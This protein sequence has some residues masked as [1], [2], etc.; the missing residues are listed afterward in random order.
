[1]GDPFKDSGVIPGDYS[2]AN[3]QRMRAFA[4]KNPKAFNERLNKLDPDEYR[5]TRKLANMLIQQYPDRFPG[6]TAD[7]VVDMMQKIAKVETGDKNI[8]Q[9][10]KG[11][12]RGFYQIETTTAP[13]ALK[14][15]QNYQQILAPL[16]AVPLPQ[17]KLRPSADVMNLSKDQQTMLA[18]SNMVAKARTGVI[19][20]NNP[21]NTW[22]DYHWSGS[23]EQRPERIQHWIDTFR[24]S[25]AKGGW[26]YPTNTGYP[27]FAD[28]GPVTWSIVEDRPMAG[29]GMFTGYTAEPST[30]RTNVPQ[31]VQAL[32]AAREFQS[33]LKN[34]RVTEEQFKSKHGISR[35]QFRNKPSNFDVAMNQVWQ[36]AKEPFKFIGADPDL[37]RE[38]PSVGIPQAL[39]GVLMSEL[40]VGEIYQAGKSAV[41]GAGKALTKE[42]KNLAIASLLSR[43]VRN[44]RPFV[45]EAPKIVRVDPINR[46]T[47]NVKN[48][49]Q[50]LLGQHQY[51]QF[52]ED[53]YQ[54]NKS[55]YDAPLVQFKSSRPAT[56]LNTATPITEEEGMLFKQKF[57]PP[58]SAC[59]KSANAVTNRMYTDITGLPFDVNANAH[60][61][62]HME[63][64]M[65]RHGA[66]NVTSEELKVG[67]R[68]LMGNNVDQSTYVPGYT[69]DPTIRH[70]GTFAGVSRVNDELVP[71][72]FESGKNE[73]MYL[74]PINFTF[75]GPNTAKK[76]F[77]P[78]QLIDDSFGKSLVDKN[79]RYA[80]RD[81]PSV[82]TYSS[83]N[84]AVQ[85]VLTNAEAHRE[86]IKKTYDITN[87]EFDE[88]L[89]NLVGIGA[90]E[91]KL[92]GALPGSKLAKAKIAIQDKLTEAGL[93]KPIKQSINLVR[94]GLNTLEKP[95]AINLPA[96]PG[97][98][99]LEKDA[100]ILA[101]KEGV[102]FSEALNRVK[103]NYQPKPKR[104][105]LTEE[106]SKGPFRQKFQSE[107][108]RLA[109]FG[110]D[111]TSKNSLENALGQMAENYN[112]IKT[113][114]PEA[115]PR[116]LMDLT[117][118]MWNSPGKAAN[119]ELVD[120]YL[121]GKN[122][123]NPS[124]FKFDYI[125]KINQFRNNL[126]D[127][128]LRG[129]DPETKIFRGSYPEIQYK[130]GGKIRKH[131]KY[132]G[133]RTYDYGTP[134]GMTSG[135]MMQRAVGNTGAQMEFGMGGWTGY[136][137]H[138]MYSSGMERFNK[139]R[140]YTKYA[141]GG[142]VTWQ[143]ID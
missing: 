103:S 74:N 1:M 60:N 90:Q 32:T 139:V 135:P 72:I 75:T 138:T 15:Y 4:I 16:S 141:K 71:M 97:A 108:S 143:I 48:D 7:K 12:G 31:Q 79:I 120:F 2:E 104:V 106:P 62:W 137:D 89:N 3:L 122:N 70:A 18:L 85:N 41:K 25:H 128:Q 45:T 34:P 119:K 136:P 127:L 73:A 109:G 134:A 44:A 9:M 82:A 50:S 49:I 116:Q 130:K 56:F 47:V 98:A 66:Q 10:G 123:P 99:K 125:D 115:S 88:L 11:P 5:G 107:S 105:L 113:L 101:D 131:R 20:V 13:T 40:P 59:A 14:R 30:T 112:K 142:K 67:D 121:F 117:T 100:A 36:G 87:D 58:G 57:C 69:A 140:N 61:A 42:G 46:S 124:K 38:N 94:R 29:N 102:S 22:A 96:Y 55:A 118:L 63:D 23:P 6:A 84:P 39:T 26:V 37:I 77:R 65:M 133:P 27:K 110:S 91:S 92:S 86:A 8:P 43:E 24:T 54:V 33:D 114:Y 80:F 83:R 81:K 28:G 17:V 126:I 76:A 95:S 35:E 51:E 132:I 111:L 78:A 19:D 93:T 129:V 53:L 52:L 21:M 64:Q 68:I